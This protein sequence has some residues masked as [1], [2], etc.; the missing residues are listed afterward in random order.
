MVIFQPTLQLA[1][2]ASGP[3]KSFLISLDEF[4]ILGLAKTYR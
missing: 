2:G 1:L 4:S 3:S